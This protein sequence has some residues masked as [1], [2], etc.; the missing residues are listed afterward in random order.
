MCPVYNMCRD[1]DR[2]GTEVMANQWLSQIETHPM[3]K[4]QPL[5]Y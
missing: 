2:V 4:N 1:K 5:H 3:G